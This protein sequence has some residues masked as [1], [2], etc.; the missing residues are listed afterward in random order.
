MQEV[1]P[2]NARPHF[3]QNVEIEIGVGISS[4]VCVSTLSCL[5]LCPDLT[6]L[7][8]LNSR[9]YTCSCEVYTCEGVRAFCI[10]EFCEIP[11]CLEI[12]TQTHSHQLITAIERRPVTGL[13]T[14]GYGLA[15]QRKDNE[16][17][18]IP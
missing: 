5:C 6:G 18:I 2:S 4:R 13:P 11:S 9:E 7:E 8:V 14:D 10:W 12:K 15:C 16:R 1:L 3:L 17:L